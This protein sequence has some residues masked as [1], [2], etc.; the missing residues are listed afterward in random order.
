MF[1]KNWITTILG[2]VLGLVAAYLADGGQLSW[3]AFA[4]YIVPAILGLVTKDF[5]TSGKGEEA[6]K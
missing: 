4:A 3:K 1:T 6:S 5:N 2:Q